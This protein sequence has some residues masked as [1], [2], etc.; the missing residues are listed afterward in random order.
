MA[1]VYLFQVQK[2]RKRKFIVNIDEFNKV[3]D[4]FQELT[5]S[6]ITLE[7]NKVCYLKVIG[8]HFYAFHDMNVC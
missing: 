8:I 3:Y 4:Y 1:L 5:K 7:K 6:D 2:E